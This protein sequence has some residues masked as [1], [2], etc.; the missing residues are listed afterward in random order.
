MAGHTHIRGGT[1]SITVV[2]CALVAG[3]SAQ[4]PTAPE[5]VGAAAITGPTD[6]PAPSP[7]ASSASLSLQA[8]ARTSHDFD[9][10]EGSFTLTFADG[11]ALWGTYHGDARLPSSG[12]PRASLEGVVTGGTG[13]FAG[14]TGSLRGRGTGGFAGDG[15][16]TVALR[17]AVSTPDSGSLDLRAT[18]KGTSTS[19]CTLT[20]PPRMALDGSGSARGLASVTGRLE[21]NLGTQICAIIVE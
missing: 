12:Q 21:H 2:L 20:A 15:E 4:A 11:S 7:A 10:L 5:R 14:A 17:A 8:S 9:L 6:M 3:C 16:F 13:L 19:T 18:L 1:L